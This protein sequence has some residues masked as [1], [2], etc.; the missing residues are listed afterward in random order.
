MAAAKIW[1]TLDVV[2]E[3]AAVEA[4]E[5]GLMEAGASGVEE[6]LPASGVSEGELSALS[7]YFDV[8]PDAE[9]VRAAI[10]E[11]LRIHSLPAFDEVVREVR[12]REVAA[13]D[14][15]AE[16]KAGWQPV[17]VGERLLI[18]PPWREDAARRAE[19]A[20]RAAVIIEPGMAFG[21][22]THETTRLCLTMIERHFDGDSFLD[23]GTGTGILAIAAAKLRPAA[24]V[25][26][27]DTDAEAVEIAR[28]NARL[29]GVAER[30]AFRVGSV[31]AATASASCVCANLTTDVIVPLLPD[32]LNATC[33]RLILSGILATQAATIAEH[34]RRAGVVNY[35]LASDGEWVAVVV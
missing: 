25:E 17:E 16:W 28:V 1:Y 7:G 14:W 19:A 6:Q 34:L 15:L 32:L 35:S 10:G 12:R 23:V 8:V 27:C 18:A 30:I 29:N 26:A 3:T 33:E 20:G 21:T 31:D 13:R 9:S 11:A 4:V 5:Y 2:C 22:G 24:R